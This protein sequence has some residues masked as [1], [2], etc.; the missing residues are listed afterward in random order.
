MHNV[1]N[2]VDNFFDK[3]FKFSVVVNLLETGF[4]STQTCG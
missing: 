1:D 3:N 4:I 2:F